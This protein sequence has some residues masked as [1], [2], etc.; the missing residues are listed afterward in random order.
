MR[1]ARLVPTRWCC[2]PARDSSDTAGPNDTPRWR[3]SSRAAASMSSSNDR[4][5]RR[6]LMLP[7][8]SNR[9]TELVLPR[10]HST[11]RRAHVWG[12]GAA[13]HGRWIDDARNGNH[14]QLGD[15]LGVDATRRVVAR[16]R[17]ESWSGREPTPHLRPRRSAGRPR[18]TQ[19]AGIAS[20]T[21]RADRSYRRFSRRP[22]AWAAIEPVKRQYDSPPPIFVESRRS[23]TV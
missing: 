22:G 19:P 7:P 11:S 15:V 4:V 10:N 20:D 9:S 16:R 17:T 14:V 13:W 12:R 2:R 5:V 6:H 23:R 8:H 21:W 3:A 1:P 18:L